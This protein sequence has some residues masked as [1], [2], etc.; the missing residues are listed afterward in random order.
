MKEIKLKLILS[1]MITI[2]GVAGIL[3]T[4]NK[5]IAYQSIYG[6]EELNQLKD[7]INQRLS[8]GCKS[9]FSFLQFNADRNFVRT[10]INNI[11]LKGS[12]FTMKSLSDL[13]MHEINLE[14][15]NYRIFFRGYVFENVKNKT[16][17]GK[18]L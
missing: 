2:L 15:R 3:Y 13:Y 1:A 6:R 17:L 12:M 5:N 8:L 4:Y 9:I 7:S 11:E 18:V 10:K 14:S 16:C